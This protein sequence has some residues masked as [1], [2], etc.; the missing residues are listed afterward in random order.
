[1][2]NTRVNVGKKKYREN[3]DKRL[4]DR[5]HNDLILK[6]KIPC[7]KYIAIVLSMLS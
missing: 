7:I 6:T 3:G 2:Q 5:D 4:E 1:M